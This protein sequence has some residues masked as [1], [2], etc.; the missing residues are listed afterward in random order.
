LRDDKNGEKLTWQSA[1][2]NKH[3]NERRGRKEEGTRAR[4]MLDE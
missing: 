4:E 3:E 2:N 1:T